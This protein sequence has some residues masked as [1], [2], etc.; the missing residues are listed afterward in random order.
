MCLFLTNKSP[1]VAEENILVFKIVHIVNNK[2]NSYFKD[3]PY[4]QGE[5]YNSEIEITDSH[6]FNSYKH[7][8]EKALHSYDLNIC[9]VLHVYDNKSWYNIGNGINEE[10]Y[11]DDNAY[12]GLFVIPKGSIYY[13]SNFCYASNY[14]ICLDKFFTFEEW[15]NKRG[16]I[17]EHAG[18]TLISDAY[19]NSLKLRN[20]VY[21][22]LSKK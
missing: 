4:R 7:A 21:V 17:K 22:H 5:S 2:I 14:L 19:I 10:T 16:F 13:A 3:M 6:Y 12:V 9:Q 15:H 20:F 8:V 11:I 1:R 18:K